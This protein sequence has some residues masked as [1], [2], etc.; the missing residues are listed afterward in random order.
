M[1]VD[2]GPHEH[3]HR[4]VATADHDRRGLDLGRVPGPSLARRVHAVETHGAELLASSG[5]ENEQR[6]PASEDRDL[7]GLVADPGH[8]RA[9]DDGAVVSDVVVAAVSCRAV[10]DVEAPLLGTVG[11]VHGVEQP[12]VVT[13]VKGA[14]DDG[15]LRRDRRLG[16]EVP[17]R[18]Q[19]RRVVIRRRCSTVRV[20]YCLSQ[21]CVEVVNSR[22]G[23]LSVR[24]TR[25]PA[26]FGFR[27][28]V[29][30]VG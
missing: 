7:A 16:V 23:Y 29:L 15:R 22:S 12:G 14:A 11:G 27:V 24:I 17:L 8:G 1:L 4:A 13:H 21:P 9:V 26:R 20:S 2:V 6:R 5:V 25:G 18:A 28:S 30:C 19:R 3:V 10:V